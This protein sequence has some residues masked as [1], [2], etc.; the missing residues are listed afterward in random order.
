MSA[1]RSVEG[2]CER[3]AGPFRA[4]A[5]DHRR[6]CSKTCSALTRVAV[7]LPARLIQRESRSLARR[8]RV[9][10][11]RIEAH[12]EWVVACLGCGEPVGSGPG[13]KGYKRYCSRACYQASTRLGDHADARRRAKDVRRARKRNAFVADVVRFEIYQRDGWVCQICGDPVEREA[14]V[15]CAKAPT[16]DHRLALSRGGTHEPSNVQLAH[17]LCNAL[18]GDR[19]WEQGSVNLPEDRAFQY[20]APDRNPDPLLERARW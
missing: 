10:E 8:M 16:L 14:R 17:F 6:F 1:G 7:T 19:G 13:W 9:L 18:K 12:P 11:A 3:C 2:S 4:R 15:P 5:R 20:R